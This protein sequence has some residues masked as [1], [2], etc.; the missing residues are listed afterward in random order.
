MRFPQINSYLKPQ[1][2]LSHPYLC[3]RPSARSFKAR[4]AGCKSL[5]QQVNWWHEKLDAEG[6]PPPS[7]NSLWIRLV[8]FSSIGL[9]GEV[10]SFNP[11][12]IAAP[13]P[14]AWTTSRSRANISPN[15][16]GLFQPFQIE[17]PK[18]KSTDRCVQCH[19]NV[20]HL[21]IN[22]NE[23]LLFHYPYFPATTWAWMC[24]H[25]AM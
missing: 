3:F 11:I 1:H 2:I 9:R 14:C 20:L 19:H 15:T 12:D 16:P 10:R 8:A 24:V 6:K 5:G 25:A 22:K 4:R 17:A 7:C 18:D 21:Q 23:S 13:A